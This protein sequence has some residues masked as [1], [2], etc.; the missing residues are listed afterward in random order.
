MSKEFNSKKESPTAGRGSINNY[1]SNLAQYLSENFYKTPNY[2]GVF[3][4]VGAASPTLISSSRYFYDLGWKVIRIEPNPKWIKE[5]QKLGL[6]IEP[7]ACSN[8][9]KDNVNF[10]LSNI[11]QDLSFTCLAENKNYDCKKP[12]NYSPTTIKVNVRTL[13][14]ILETNYPE[15]N[16]VDVLAID[17]EG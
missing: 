11:N 8:Y 14:W 1:Y 4:D 9:I 6:S 5:Y 15:I 3:I 16:K 2:T 12:L 13:D 17:V 7:H 10:E